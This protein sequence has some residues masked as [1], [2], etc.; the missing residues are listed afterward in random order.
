MKLMSSV[1]P[2]PITSG[3]ESA[4]LPSALSWRSSPILNTP[5]ET[6]MGCESNPPVAL[7]VKVPSPV[8][9]IV[10]VP[11]S[12][13][14]PFSVTSPSVAMVTSFASTSPGSVIVPALATVAFA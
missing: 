4:A 5:F 8:L 7:N 9:T 1:A 6:M 14:A 12:L 13:P 2:F 3:E 10:P 11:P